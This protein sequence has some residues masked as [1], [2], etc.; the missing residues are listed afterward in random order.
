MLLP[1]GFTPLPDMRLSRTNATACVLENPR[2]KTSDPSVFVMGG[3]SG[4]CEPTN[5]VD[6]LNMITQ[7]A[8]PSSHCPS[9]VTGYMLTFVAA[10][11]LAECASFSSV[12]T[13][14]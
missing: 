6:T 10:P 3:F 2:D 14:N 12:L 11:F 4:E 1:G 13:L 7:V 5:R 8:F 9:D